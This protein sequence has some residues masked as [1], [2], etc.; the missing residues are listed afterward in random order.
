MRGLRPTAS[1]AAFGEAPWVRVSVMPRV[2]AVD[3]VRM[4]LKPE[5]VESV[6]RAVLLLL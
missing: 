6:T 3:S 4:R 2:V 5:S 1:D